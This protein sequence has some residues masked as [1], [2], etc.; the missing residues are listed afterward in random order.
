MSALKQIAE[1]LWG[2]FVD[3]GLVALAFFGWIVI[4]ALLLPR[5]HLAAAGG[6]VLFLG[7]AAIVVFSLLR[8]ARR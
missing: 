1:E 6:P 4:A 7:C 2:L 5:L 3:D 8:A